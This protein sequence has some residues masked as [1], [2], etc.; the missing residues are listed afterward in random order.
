[1]WELPVGQ[2]TEELASA[3]RAAAKTDEFQSVIEHMKTLI[4]QFESETWDV[5]GQ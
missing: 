3:E 2:V 1:M 4:D 5:I